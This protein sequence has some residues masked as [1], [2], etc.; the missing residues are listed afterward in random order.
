MVQFKREQLPFLWGACLHS[1]YSFEV[2][3]VLFLKRFTCLFALTCKSGVQGDTPQ[4]KRPRVRSPAAEAKG[5]DKALKSIDA[6]DSDKPDEPTLLDLSTDEKLFNIG[7][8]TKDENKPDALRMTRTGLQKEG[9]RV[10][11]GVPKPGKKRKFMEVSK[12][13]VADRSSKINEA[14]E[15][16]KFAKYLM[17]QGSGP[18]GWKSTSKTESHEKRAAL[19]KPKVVK[20]GKPQNVSGR[21]IPQKDN[22]SST[23][24]SAPNDGVITDHTAKTKDSVSHVENTSGKQNL[25][26]FQSL[27]GSE[28]TAE[29]PILF[30]SLALPSDTLS[31]KK[32]S[33]SNAKPERVSKGKLAP[34][35]GKLGK[36]DEDKI[37]NGSS[38]K[39]T[40]D[41]VEPRRS[42]RRIQPT[43]RVSVLIFKLSYYKT[44]YSFQSLYSSSQTL[45]SVDN[46]LVMAF[47][48]F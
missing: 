34:L 13:Y 42:N 4:E 37:F 18:R 27:S 39:P 46:N 11:F 17:P 9:S 43:S 44:E 8:S 47:N 33:T 38:A 22:L 29:G 15:S 2:S 30:S 26:E 28:G 19:S 35:D 32:M 6:M 31:S 41:V 25:M 36:I 5:K 14:N 3:L 12:H 7:K 20:S 48:L 16:A 23:A 40:A 45:S 10:I 1:L 21:T 24:V